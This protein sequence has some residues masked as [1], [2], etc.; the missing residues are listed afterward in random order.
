MTNPNDFIN[1][2]LFSSSSDG[3]TVA[4]IVKDCPDV[5]SVLA[6]EVTSI[7]IPKHIRVIGANTFFGCHNLTNITFEAQS[8]LEEIQKLAF[9][10]CDKLQSIDLPDSVTTV[11]AQAFQAC[12]KLQ[13]VTFG[14]NI[15]SL[16]S[17]IFNYCG[18]LQ[19][20]T[21]VGKM[22][23]DVSQMDGYPWNFHFN[24][25]T[26][27]ITDDFLGHVDKKGRPIL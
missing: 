7:T 3:L 5:Y 14:K 15:T 6:S 9:C 27:L 23:N 10:F 17:G 8:K 24:D 11:K 20:I 1:D 26:T 4:T 16:E 22:L 2:I 13:S 18:K 19:Y 12:S 25:R 21:F